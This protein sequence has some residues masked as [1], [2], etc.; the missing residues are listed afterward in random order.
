[1]TRINDRL[2][3]QNVD[4]DVVILDEHTGAEI[5]IPR[6]QLWHTAMAVWSVATADPEPER[7]VTDPTPIVGMSG[8]RF[9]ENIIV[10]E[11]AWPDFRGEIEQT[12]DR[13]RDRDE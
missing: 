1:M 12:I 5:V 8:A 3:V 10:D 6:A 11:I 13:M 9:S 4:G 7:P 2:L